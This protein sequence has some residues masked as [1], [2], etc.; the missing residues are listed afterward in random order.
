MNTPVPRV[1]VD[2]PE[3]MNLLGLLMEGLVADNLVRLAEHCRQC[4]R[5]TWEY[6]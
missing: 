4:E 1:T 3:S 6:W 2:H 5:P